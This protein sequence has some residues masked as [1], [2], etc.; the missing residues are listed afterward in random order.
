[1]LLAVM[2]RESGAS[3]N[4]RYR[5]TR[6]RFGVLDRPLS[7]TMTA[8]SLCRHPFSASRRA[9]TA[10]CISAM[11]CRRC[12]MPTWRARP[13]GGC[14]CASR[15]STR[16]AAGRN[17]RRRS[18]RTSPGSGIA[19]EQPVRRQ[20]EHFDDYRAALAKLEAAGP[21]LSELRKPRR[22]RARWSPSARRRAPLA[23]RSRR[24][25]ALS[26]RARRRW[27]PPSARAAWPPASLMRCASTWRPRWRATGP[28]TWTETGAGPVRRN[29]QHRRRSRRL[30]RRD[31]G[32]QGDAD[33]LSSGGG[34]RRRGARRHRRGARPRPVP[35]DQRAPAAAGAAR[36]AAPRYHHHRLILDADGRKLSK[37]T[38]ATGL[39]ELRA[40]RR[41]AV[42]TSAELVGL[43]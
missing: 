19:W 24:R 39:R 22:D 35:R 36:P 1:M 23:A 16:R 9:R 40:Q 32:A 20:S 18:T 31:P 28:L 2:P 26:R 12:S 5:L 42:R 29:R 21:D 14:C 41:D 30:G 4:P 25:A 6:K 11:R 15:T 43:D 3:S 27:P 38:Q 37:S 34:G 13:A 33:Q 7:R 8:E 10:I 17:T